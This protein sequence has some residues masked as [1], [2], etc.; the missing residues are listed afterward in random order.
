[1]LRLYSFWP[2]HEYP[3]DEGEAAEGEV[4]TNRQDNERFHV[5][6]SSRKGV[7]IFPY[8]GLSTPKLER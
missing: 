1:M 8:I 7:V 3:I 2:A 5:A 6:C 4:D